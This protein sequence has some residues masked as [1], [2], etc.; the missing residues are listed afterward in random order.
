ME[1]IWKDIPGYE[2]IYQASNLGNIKALCIEKRRGRGIQKREEIILKP[3]IKERGYLQVCLSVD[4]KRV[5]TGIH[6]LVALAF[7]PNPENKPTVNHKD[8]NK[9]DNSVE[10][11]EW[12]THKEQT[13]HADKL[14]LRKISGE[15]SKVSKLKDE[16]VLY[17]RKNYVSD[18]KR[19]TSNGKELCAKFGIAK[20]TLYRVLRKTSYSHI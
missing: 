4:S 17:I 20:T 11:L 5:Y 3:S 12:A 13:N 14:G 2:G 9:G 7:I 8:G 6:R 15:D 1:E 16:D 19:Q 10:N 18:L